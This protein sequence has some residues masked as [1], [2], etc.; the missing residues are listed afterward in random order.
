MR[1]MSLKA[2][3]APVL[4]LIMMLMLTLA[5]S[6]PASP[7]TGAAPDQTP[8]SHPV[9]ATPGVVEQVLLNAR[10]W[11]LKQQRQLQRQLSERLRQLQ[12][13]PSATTAGVLVLVSFLY[14]VLHASGPGHGKLVIS[15]YLLTHRQRARQGVLIATLA[16]LAQGVTAI[17]LVFALVKVGGWLA[18]DAVGQVR[19]VNMISFTLV[20]LL[21]AWLILRGL[22]KLWAW[23]GSQDP[24]RARGDRQALASCAAE[25]VLPVAASPGLGTRLLVVMAVGIR[26]C[27][28]AVMV[29]AVA[30]LLNLWLA[31]IL[32]VLAMSLGTAITVSL[33]ATLAVQANYWLER[34]PVRPHPYWRLVSPI[35]T[36]LGGLA[37]LAIGL[38]LLQ[39]SAKAPS[40]PLL[41]A[42]VSQNVH[43]V[44]G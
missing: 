1:V 16:A 13:T 33:L 38:L 11:V 29:L 4:M 19:L 26:P 22:R 12:A 25:S 34:L 31:G 39:G 7:L 41:S 43:A 27:T 42:T 15:T 8:V 18:R 3:L 28:G 10:A 14:G 9:Q 24:A 21:G 2:R 44:G 30:N 20:A 23:R 35:S 17:V 37:I 40:H 36:I 5:P 32:A 6:A